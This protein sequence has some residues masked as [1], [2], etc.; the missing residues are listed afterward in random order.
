MCAYMRVCL[1]VHAFVSVHVCVHVSVFFRCV[2][3]ATSRARENRT[4]FKH[5][6]KTFPYVVQTY[7]SVSF[8][9]ITDSTLEISRTSTKH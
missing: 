1:C 5:S 7:R 8:S 4:I 2:C 9:L 3:V 6:I